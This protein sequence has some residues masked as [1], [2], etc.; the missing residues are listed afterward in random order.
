MTKK[1][2]DTK[3]LFHKLFNLGIFIKGLDG[4][5]E[6]LGGILLFFV[7]SDNIVKVLR[8]L[9]QIEIIQDSK[10][11]IANYLISIFQSLSLSAQLFASIYLL[12][13]GII[14]LWLMSSL[15]KRRLWAYPVSQ[16]ILGLFV[17]YQTYRYTHTHSSFLAFL[18]LFDILII[19]LIGIEWKEVKKKL[20]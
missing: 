2:S 17:I 8:Y 6:I 20:F 12:I 18:T 16:V 15:S 9:F 11:A 7:S 13:H 5:L 10:D 3:T 14:K 1:K 4:V 19:F